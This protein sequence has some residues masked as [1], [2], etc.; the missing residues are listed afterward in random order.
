M[1]IDQQHIKTKYDEELLLELTTKGETYYGRNIPYRVG[2]IMLHSS[3]AC[4]TM[5]M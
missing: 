1:I 3:E 2:P 5:C 4:T